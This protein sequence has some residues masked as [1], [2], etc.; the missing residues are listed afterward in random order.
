LAHLQA[1]TS[2]QGFAVYAL[3]GLLGM[4]TLVLALIGLFRDGFG[5][6]RTGLAI[7]SLL[8]AIFVMTASAGRNVPR[9]NDMTT[10]VDNPPRFVHAGQI[11]ANRGRDMAYPGA[12]FAAQQRAGYPN[13]KP[14]QLSTSPDEVFKRVETT[15]RQHS[16]WELTHIDP[17]ARTLE[18][19]AT[20]N[21]FRFQDDFIVEVRAQDAGS[22]V[23]MRSK[24]RDGR[25]DLGANAARIEAFFAEIK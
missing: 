24:S 7:G 17:A 15:A 12:D 10:D 8:T 19:V 23:Q 11:D 1:L 22:V 5:A 21:L 13:L 14:L 16:N 4:I 9:I 2:L 18:G 20:T 3:G 25:G 6:A